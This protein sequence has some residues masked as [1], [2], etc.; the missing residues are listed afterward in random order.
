MTMFEFAIARRFNQLQVERDTRMLK[1]DEWQLL[2]VL[3]PVIDRYEGF[4]RRLESAGVPSKSSST[5]RGQKKG[6]A[7]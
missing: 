1:Q 4:E 2:G 5:G 7:V 3:A 6:S